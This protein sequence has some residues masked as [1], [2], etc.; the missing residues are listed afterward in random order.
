MSWGVLFK[1]PAGP[2]HVTIIGCGK[3]KLP[4]KHRAEDLYTGGLFRA[5]LEYAKRTSDAVYIVS[6]SIKQYAVEQEWLRQRR[7]AV[8]S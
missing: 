3:S 2:L 4:G 1:N 8:T 5:S 6:A 7:A